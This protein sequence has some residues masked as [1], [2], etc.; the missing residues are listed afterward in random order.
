[1]ERNTFGPKTTVP[2]E[3][4]QFT[5]TQKEGIHK[6]PET[7]L[8]VFS[9]FIRTNQ[10]IQYFYIYEKYFNLSIIFEVK[11]FVFL[12]IKKNQKL[13][14]W[15]DYIYIKHI[16][17]YMVNNLHIFFNTSFKKLNLTIIDYEIITAKIATLFRSLQLI[18]EN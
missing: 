4:D 10:L 14:N 13:L 17:P 12:I 18:D 8:L 6:S 15:S 16:P 1:M 5:T 11:L 7:C 3:Y 9:N 2:S